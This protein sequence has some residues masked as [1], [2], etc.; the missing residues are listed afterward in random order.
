VA[1]VCDESTSRA[2]FPE[3]LLSP[4]YLAH[5]TAFP[6][7]TAFN[8]R[9]FIKKKSKKKIEKRTGQLIMAAFGAKW[10]IE[11]NINKL[12][13]ISW[14]YKGEWKAIINMFYRV[15]FLQFNKNKKIMPPYFQ[16]GLSNDK[17]NDISNIVI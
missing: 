12:L 17:S 14:N 3:N 1:A 9:K 7:S 15:W 8:F 5:A 10:K 13:F 2:Q 6:L 4:V 11:I 16:L